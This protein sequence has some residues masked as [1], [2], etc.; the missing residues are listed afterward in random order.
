M[1][2]LPLEK[3]ELQDIKTQPITDADLKMMRHRADSYQSLFSRR[4]LKFRS[5]GLNQLT[6]NEE[7]YKNWILKEYT[8]L[9]RPVVIIDDAIF[10]GSA[11]GTIVQ[12]HEGIDQML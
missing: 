6:L 10:I 4:A 1:K 12:L 5:L 3:F 11:K 2:N 7:D 8:F 9:K